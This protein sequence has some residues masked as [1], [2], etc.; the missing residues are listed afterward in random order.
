MV[1]KILIVDDEPD[2]LKIIV[3]RLRKMGYEISTVVNGREALDL[4][5]I[6]IPDLILLDVL[7]PIISGYEVCRRI[8]SD[9]KLSRI[10]VVLLTACNIR[11]VL[12]KA[13]EIGADDYLSKPFESKELLD[14]IRKFIG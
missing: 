7:L 4:L 5:N 9:L 13:E 8:K 2:L 11:D 14:K 12:K 6:K 10:P 1:K 3:Y